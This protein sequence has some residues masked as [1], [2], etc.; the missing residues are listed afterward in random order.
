MAVLVW[1]GS[2]MPCPFIPC[3]LASVLS[4][5]EN[6]EEYVKVEAKHYILST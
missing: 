1:S 6:K 3:D 5:F 4:S 2:R